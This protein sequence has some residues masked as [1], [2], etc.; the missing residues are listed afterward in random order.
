MAISSIHI[1]SGKIGFFCH[2]DRSRKTKN[3]IFFDESNFYSCSSK[4]A[5]STYKRELELRTQAYIKNHPTRKKLHSK[6]LTHL[7]SIINLNSHHNQDDLK[8]VCNYLEQTLD[9][10]I[11]QFSIHRDEGHVDKIKNEA[12]KNYHGHIEF[13]GLDSQGNSV[14]RKL[15]KKYLSSLQ[16]EVATLLQMERGIN[17]AKEQ[18][19]RP[20]RLG[21]YE[22][23]K[24]KEQETNSVLAKQKD[25]KNEIANIRAELQNNQATREQYKALELLQKDLKAH[26]KNKD[27]TI[28]TLNDT[29]TQYRQ[30]FKKYA[31][32]QKATIERLEQGNIN[33][34]KAKSA[35]TKESLEAEQLIN[36]IFLPDKQNKYSFLNK[37]KGF[38]NIFKNLQS[39]LK[40]LNGVLKNKNNQIQKLQED[41][42]HLKN[43]V[44]EIE[45]I[46][47]DNVGTHC[48]NVENNL[49][50]NLTP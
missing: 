23:K 47:N 48:L 7:S 35:A 5:I 14:R 13:M 46:S 33:L 18:K 26:I 30:D 19:L 45:D 2:N 9:T 49:S 37:I 1:E 28:Q 8:K 43:V 21:T 36:T 3:S 34:S 44:L 31:D 10:K 42:N 38:I 41:N 50:N 39:K 16:T 4:N 17:Y 15:S 6:T 11:L 20:K 25:L 29:L 12:I 40:E 32:E 27:L 24:A 22:Y